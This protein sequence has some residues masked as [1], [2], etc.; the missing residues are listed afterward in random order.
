MSND[1]LDIA[2]FK[3]SGY[4]EEVNRLF[5]HPLGLALEVNCY[6]DGACELAG[7]ID[8]RNDPEGFI[9]GYDSWPDPEATKETARKHARFVAKEKDSRAGARLDAFGWVVQ[10]PGFD[11]RT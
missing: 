10:P 4:L 11:P 6:E 7:I 3:E 5:F 8:S 9:M 2:E 1:W